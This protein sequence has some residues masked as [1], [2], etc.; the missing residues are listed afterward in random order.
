MLG[1]GGVVDVLQ[2]TILFP[3]QSFEYIRYGAT[4]FATS[5]GCLPFH[6]HLA[7]LLLNFNITKCIWL[8]VM[9]YSDTN[10]HALISALS[11]LCKSA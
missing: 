7:L 8:H 4:A 9:I 6:S 5:C 11:A 10:M 2:S 1:E 3:R